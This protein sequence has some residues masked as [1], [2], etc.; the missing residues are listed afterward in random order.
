M[1]IFYFNWKN[2]KDLKQERQQVSIR[3]SLENFDQTQLK[4][5]DVEEK[6]ILPKAEG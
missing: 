2:P 6:N 4:H 5:V 1:F 3:Q